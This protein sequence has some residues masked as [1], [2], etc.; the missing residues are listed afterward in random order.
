MKNIF[1]YK[2]SYNGICFQLTNKLIPDEREIHAYH[3]I[4]YF[5][6]GDVVLLTENRQEKLKNNSLIIIPKESYHFFRLQSN[7][8]FLRLK[9]SIPSSLYKDLPLLSEML[10]IKILESPSDN[11]AFVLSRLYT[12]LV[13]EKKPFCAY[14]VCMHLLAELDMS[15]NTESIKN[16]KQNN[17]LAFG[18][19]E[20]ISKNLSKDLS[21]NAIAQKMNVSA[22]SITHIFKKE[23]G[24]SVHEYVQQKRLICAKNLIKKNN[25]P[26]KIYLDCG[27]QDYSSFYK[28]YIRFFGYPPSK[29]KDNDI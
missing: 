26:S 2:T 29:E 17:M 14:A 22:S 11:I 20:Y 9:I 12:L 8:S 23:L 19:T 24:I 10:S 1:D 7:K 25:K 5:I 13:N 16:S 6:E 18:I 28:A 4:L 3:E 27:Y 15:E 21:I